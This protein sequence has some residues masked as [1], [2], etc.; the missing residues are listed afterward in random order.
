[1]SWT[2]ATDPRE[3]PS[4]CQ[5]VEI[6]IVPRARDIGGFEVRRALPSGKR[7]MVGPF[8][9]FDQMGPADLEPG[10]GIDVRPHPHIGLATVTYLFQGEMVHRDSLGNALPIRPGAVNWMNAGKGIT[11][12][13]RTGQEARAAGGPLWGI[14]SWVAL[15]ES[16]EEGEPAFSHHAAGDLPLIEDDGRRIRLIAGTFDGIRSPVDPGW[17][18]LYADVGLQH[19]A[20]LPIPADTEERAI[21]TVNGA[22]QIAG[23]SFQAGQLLILRPGDRVEVQAE[24]AA[25]FMVFGGATMDSPRHIWWNFV[26]SSPD[27]IRQAAEDWRAGRFPGVPGDK[28]FIPLPEG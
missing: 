21:Y 19:G 20:R 28:E 9:F 10:N 25:R 6:R 15:P 22:I 16:E 24:T 5:P 27:R 7:Q 14:Q 11:H 1:M 8:I 4:T 26:S 2:K 3:A 13:E 23:E 12:S 17:E 18:T